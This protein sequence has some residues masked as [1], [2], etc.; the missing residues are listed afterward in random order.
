MKNHRLPL[1]SIVR[2]TG[3]SLACALL[4]ALF[5]ICSPVVLAQ[6][7]T[8]QIAGR[9]SNDRTGAYLEGASVSIE[10]SS[11]SATTD[12]NG[13]FIFT[14]VAAGSHTVIVRYTGFPDS[15]HTATVTDGGVARIEV[16]LGSDVQTLETFTITATKEGNAVAITRQRNAPN[17]VNVVSLDAYGNVA[18]SNM[19]T[20][21][22]KLPGVGA[23]YLEGDITGIM[24][25]GSPPNQSMVAI[26]GT[27]MAAAVA[28]SG[29]AQ[30][31][32]APAID[33]IPSEFIKEIEVN[34]ALTPD[35]PADGLGGS[36]N[37]I[38]K[39][40]FDFRDRVISYRTALIHNTYRG[41]DFTPSAGFTLMDTLG[42]DRKFAIALSG[43][44][45]ET[46]NTR[47]RMETTFNEVDRRQTLAR[48]LDDTYTRVRAGAGLKVEYQPDESL[49]IYAS[50]YYSFF[51]NDT[52]RNNSQA[53]DTATRRVADYNVVSRAAIEAGAVPRTTAG[54]TASVAPGYTDTFTEMLHADF[55]LQSAIEPRRNHQYNYTIGG[56]KRWD[57]TELKAKLTHNPATFTNE[58][59]GL[60]MI[61]RGIGVAIDS[62]RD[63]SRPTFNQTY[64]RT[65]ILHGTDLSQYTQQTR[66]FRQPRDVEETISGASLDLK[67]SFRDFPLV[68]KAGFDFRE[69]DRTSDT[70]YNPSW[71]Y[72]GPDRLQFSAGRPAYGLFNGRYPAREQLSYATALRVFASNPEQFTPVGTS[73]SNVPPPTLL[74]EQVLAGYTMGTLKWRRFTTLAG[75]RVEETRVDATGRYTDPRQT[76][77]TTIRR[78]G[79]YR[80][81]FPSVHFKYEPSRNFIVR[82]SYS[83]SMARPSINQI[84][85]TTS[86]SHNDLTGLGVVNSPNPGLKPQY[87]E[88]LDLMVEYYF[89]P[90]GV[91]SAGVFR[92][93]IEDYIFNTTDIIGSGSGNGFDGLYEGYELRTTGNFSSAKVEGFELNYNQRLRFLPG[94]FNGL[95]VFANYTKLKTNGTFDEGTTELANHYPETANAGF[96]WGIRAFEVSAS[97]NYKSD[98]LEVFNV[99]PLSSRRAT[100]DRRV[101]AS[102]KYRFRP[103]LVAYVDAT[104][105]FNYTPDRYRVS[106]DRI[107]FSESFGTRLSVGFSGRF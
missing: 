106:T 57:Q 17:V 48:L 64:G 87:A 73:V 100:F 84:T 24:L 21:M 31:D 60:T 104:N 51:S 14:G 67:H 66:I 92:K 4:T 74:N 50:A 28:G 68:V 12:R 62:S 3:H 15:I 58:F 78:K 16:N 34:K 38:T 10:G 76:G 85:P 32:R 65:T 30:G 23:L 77:V 96:T 94:I 90:A 2:K 97:W 69:Q 19:G 99:N 91:F 45:T 82:A 25:R 43:S 36:A 83:T 27:R 71:D 98:L 18:D 59:Q 33:R 72:V 61:M 70:A 75:V 35:M 47:D 13:A 46:V 103:W 95:S 26:D 11:R 40:G 86:I 42:A 1:Q 7:A 101:D 20:F 5:L 80:N 93:D 37:L 102:V 53:N 41:D 52:V 88:N 79:D 6:T 54:L 9:V 56:T 22:E 49:N 55:Q 39:S 89:E 107:L 8:G 44:Y 105:I 63:S 81:T 29:A